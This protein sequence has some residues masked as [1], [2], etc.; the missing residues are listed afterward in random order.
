MYVVN[1]K[2]AVKVSSK[3]QINS[4]VALKCKTQ[5]ILKLMGYRYIIW[6]LTAICLINISSWNK[7]V[8]QLSYSQ[9][10]SINKWFGKK[11]RKDSCFLLH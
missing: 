9:Y 8:D 6:D 10:I 4:I 7:V 3:R 5:R 1:A 11:Y 2:F